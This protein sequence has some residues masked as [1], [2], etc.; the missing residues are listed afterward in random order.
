MEFTSLY[1]YIF[2]AIVVSIYYLIPSLKYRWYSLL[3]GS[4]FFYWYISRYSKQSFLML[5]GAAFICWLLSFLMKNV[6]GG[7][8]EVLS[9][10]FNSHYC[11]TSFGYQGVTLCS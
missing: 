6:K 9:C 4:L 10:Y 11:D 7:G 1:F 2:L 8:Q 3:A 5:V